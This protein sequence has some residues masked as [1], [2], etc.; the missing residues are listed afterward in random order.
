MNNKLTS[1]SII[2]YFLNHNMV[3]DTDYR[4]DMVKSLYPYATTHNPSGIL[5][6]AILKRKMLRGDLED[7]FSKYAALNKGNVTLLAFPCVCD[8]HLMH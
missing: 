2:S 4:L 5:L 3:A 1:I 7:H 6:K 8:L